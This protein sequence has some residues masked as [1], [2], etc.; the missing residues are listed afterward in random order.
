MVFC[1]EETSFERSR[2][3]PMKIYSNKSAPEQPLFTIPMH[4]SG[5]ISHQLVV[6][7]DY[8]MTKTTCHCLRNDMLRRV[9]GITKNNHKR[10][11]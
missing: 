7:L 8:F 4:I 3:G 10:N 11:D 6:P 2:E 1:D 9:D 5:C